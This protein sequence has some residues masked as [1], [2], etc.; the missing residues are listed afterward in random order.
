[1]PEAPLAA[2]H[3]GRELRFCAD[4]DVHQWHLADEAEGRVWFWEGC[5]F[6]I[7]EMASL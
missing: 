2:T 7:K 4:I 5:S 6:R 3:L 1:M